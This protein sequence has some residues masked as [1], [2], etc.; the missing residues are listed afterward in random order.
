M[1]TKTCLKCGD[2][3]SVLDFYKGRT[4]CKN[5][6][7]RRRAA[8]HKKQRILYPDSRYAV[9]LKHKYGITLEVYKLMLEDQNNAC[10]ICQSSSPGHK[11]RYFSVDHCHKTGRIR[12]LLCQD[13][14]AGIGY[15]KDRVENLIAAISYLGG[16]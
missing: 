14:N 12:G 2:S 7:K 15:L 3:K 10:A 11:K 13:C 6:Q 1:Q 8:N 4:E 9:V 5:C 16:A